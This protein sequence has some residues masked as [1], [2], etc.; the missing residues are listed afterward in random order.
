MVV[1]FFSPKP[2]FSENRTQVAPKHYLIGKLRKGLDFY[3]IPQIQNNS[4]LPW[5]TTI[6]NSCFEFNLQ[7]NIVGSILIADYKNDPQRTTFAHI[8][9][10]WVKYLMKRNVEI[11]FT[12]LNI[13]EIY[14]IQKTIETLSLI[15]ESVHFKGEIHWYR[16]WVAHLSPEHKDKFMQQ[17]HDKLP[18]FGIIPIN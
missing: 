17:V 16:S 1:F 7:P 12:K 9:P 11:D 10:H 3:E 8:P 13:D 6:W 2:A 4:K 15:K 18:Q 14:T 5:A